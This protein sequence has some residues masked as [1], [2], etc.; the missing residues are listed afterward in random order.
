MRYLTVGDVILLH[1]LA[2]D[3]YGGSHGLRDLGLLESAVYRP[4]ATYGGED[5]YKTIFD[6]GAALVHSLLM[7]HM[8]VDGNKRTAMFSVMEFIEL[9]GY[10]FVAEQKEIVEYALYIENSQPEIEEISKWLKNHTKKRA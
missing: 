4:Q 8:F 6:K 2:V 3:N 1:N 5:L 10:E 9:N 7:N